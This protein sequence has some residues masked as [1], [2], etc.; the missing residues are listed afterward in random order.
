MDRAKI[1]TFLA[2]NYIGQDVR[3][4]GSWSGADVLSSYW[5]WQESLG[6][7]VQLAIF[8][9]VDAHSLLECQQHLSGATGD[10]VSW[11]E[12]VELA[13]MKSADWK[14]F[15]RVELSEIYTE[16]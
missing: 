15:K 12:V 16:S 11:S 7:H 1:M 8:E 9:L 10:S 5:Q 14:S 3:I 13:I 6:R 2:A 4:T